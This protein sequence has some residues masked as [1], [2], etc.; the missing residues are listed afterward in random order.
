[1]PNLVF[2]HFLFFAKYTMLRTFSH[3]FTHFLEKYNSVWYNDFRKVVFETLPSRGE[4]STKRRYR[5]MQNNEQK[6]RKG[7]RPLTPEEIQMLKAH[8]QEHLKRIATDPEYQKNWEKQKTNFRR[9]APMND[10]IETTK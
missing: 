9:A 2:N 5:N 6:T 10:S 8:R 7:P 3:E 4:D 1:M